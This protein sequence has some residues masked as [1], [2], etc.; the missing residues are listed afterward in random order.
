[1]WPQ[2]MALPLHMLCCCQEGGGCQGAL[3]PTVS[4]HLNSVGSN[5]RGA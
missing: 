3:E 2:H 4:Q 1:V 5:S